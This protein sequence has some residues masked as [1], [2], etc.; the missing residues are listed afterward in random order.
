MTNIL[1]PVAVQRFFDNNNRPASKAKLFTYIA[2]TSTKQ[3]TYSDSSGT[4]NTNPIILNYRGECNLWLDSTKTYKFVF[5]PDTDT[6]PPTNPFWTVD[7]IPGGYTGVIDWTQIVYDQTAAESAAS[8]T[9]TQYFYDTTPYG[10]IFRY[11][12]QAQIN[13]VL[14]LTATLDV[15]AAFTTAFSLNTGGQS[16][17]I[18]CPSGTY[19]C[20]T[21]VT[22]PDY[23]RLILSHGAYIIRKAA[24]SATTPVVLIKG[25]RASVTGGFIV[26]EKA[27][28]S[29]IVCCGHLDNTSAWDS[30]RWEFYDC[31]VQGLNT[32]GNL[33]VVVPNSQAT[34]TGKTNYFGYM[35]DIRIRGADI[36]LQLSEYANAHKIWGINYWDCRTACLQLRGAA[37]NEI[38]GQFMHNGAASGVIGVLFSNKTVGSQ[39]NTYNEVIGFTDETGGGADVSVSISSNTTSCTVI[40]NSNVAGG[41]SI[42]N[43]NNLV[44][45]NGNTVCQGSTEAT[46]LQADNKLII[47][48]TTSG[49]RPAFSESDN[50]TAAIG[51]GGT[52][53]VKNTATSGTITIRNA[54]DGKTSFATFDTVAGTVVIADGGFLVGA[55]TAD[56]GAGSSKFY[57]AI[58]GGGTITIINRY[59][60][61]K[62]MDVR[63]DAASS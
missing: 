35:R 55:P 43:R 20:D 2:G 27:S 56:P 7:N 46:N 23:K 9:P 58:S 44:V 10:H 54:S 50:T 31:D 37:E 39:E 25:V 14:A 47:V 40:G 5:A 17:D 19:R 1:S 38:H 53:T 21:T 60:V 63:V 26:T 32:A 4:A 36:G 45:I 13:D 34:G 59:A 18:I 12:T 62:Q 30:E 48:N 51:A 42:G 57:L 3:T 15:T 29:G 52:L 24:A 6:D 28:P 22:V 16:V 8:V 11:M 49:V 33:G 41:Y 61:S